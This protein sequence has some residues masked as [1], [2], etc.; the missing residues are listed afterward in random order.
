M[1]AIIKI[2]ILIPSLLLA[3]NVLAKGLSHE[4]ISQ[5]YYNSYSYEKSGNYPDAIKAIQLI[6]E[7]YP[8][9]YTVNS[10]LGSLYRLDGKFRNSVEHYKNALKVLPSSISAKLGLQYTYVLSENYAKTLE[11]GYQII[12]VDYYNYYANYRIVY[13]LV[14]TKKYDLAEKMIK[15]M[16]A[17]YPADVLFLT[18]FGLLQLKLKQLE[19]SKTTLLNVLILD[20]E[21]VRAKSA[22]LNIDG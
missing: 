14:Q 9:T 20:P 5:S 4:Q 1:K 17:I 13:S 3:F 2:F 6:F 21:N 7:K 18:E 22:L 11:L 19:K 16:L 8:N 12:S 10:R 15:K